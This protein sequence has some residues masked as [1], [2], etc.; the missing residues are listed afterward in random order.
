MPADTN[1]EDFINK[2]LETLNKRSKYMIG[3]PGWGGGLDVD[4]PLLFRQFIINVGSPF[5]EGAN[6]SI[7]TKDLEREVLYYFMD[8]YNIDKAKAYGYL[9][10]GASEASMYAIYKARES[11][12]DPVLLFSASSHYSIEKIAKILRIPYKIIPTDTN[13]VL[14]LDELKLALDAIEADSIILSAN[15]GTVMSGAIDDVEEIHQ[16]LTDS[17]KNFR[18]HIEAALFGG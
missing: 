13:G 9:A 8:Q 11:L 3:Y 10:N 6:Y 16:L 1:I 5:T 2:K 18:I 17:K 14:K 15:L 12:K 4:F 7:H